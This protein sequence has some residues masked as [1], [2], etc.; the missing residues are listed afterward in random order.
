MKMRRTLTLSRKEMNFYV[1]KLMKFGLKNHENH[2][3]DIK[4]WYFL[5]INCLP[6]INL[7]CHVSSD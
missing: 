7:Y 1:S 5:P 6:R 4:T 3:E 2:P